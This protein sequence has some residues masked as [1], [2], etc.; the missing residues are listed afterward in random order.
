MGH[1]LAIAA[2][3]LRI[4]WRSREI[5]FT[6]GFLAVL[7]VLVFAFAFLGGVDGS[8]DEAKREAA[9]AGRLMIEV[10]FGPAVVAGLLWVAVLFSG[11]VALARTFDREREGEAIRS[12]LLA[13]VPRAAI[14][15]GKLLGT[16]ALMA[17]VEAIVVPLTGLLMST[18]LGAHLGLLVLALALGT[19]GFAAAGVVFS[20]ALLRSKSRDVLLSALLFPTVIPVFLAGARAAS[21]LLDP[22]APDLSGPIFWIQFLAV[23]DVLYVTIGLWV[24]EPVIAGE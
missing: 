1:A 6:M 24:F 17:I 16:V 19:V 3:D 2:K 4:E 9:A 10:A 12:L 7:V 21:G 23:C 5:L 14:Y 20:A 18:R 15:V 11:T 13:P 22:A 8:L